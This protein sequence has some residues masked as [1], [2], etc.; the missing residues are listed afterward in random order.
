MAWVSSF[1]ATTVVMATPMLVAAVGT[2][3]VERSGIINIGNEGLMLT[4]AFMGVLGSWLTGSALVGAVFAMLGSAVLGLIFAFF[5]ISL[6]ANQVVS[7]L[8][9]NAMASGLTILLKRMVFGVGG[10]IPQIAVYRK[11]EIPL[12]SKIP[13]IGPTLFNQTLIAYLAI[14]LIPVLTLVLKYTRIGLELRS[15]GENPK[16]CDT[17]GIKVVRVRYLALLFG[18]MM[19]GLGGSFIS[20]GH[21]SFFTEGM[22]AGRGYMTLAAV[23]F[24]NFTPAG[25]LMACLLFGAVDALQYR[26]QAS[27]LGVPYQLMVMLP[28]LATVLAL[29]LY[30]RVSNA[31]A[32]SGVPFIRQ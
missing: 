23:V 24:G 15:V 32:N 6:Y 4:G 31:P 3:F 9:V 1:F 27:S 5:S 21:H 12:L 11:I 8:A 14:L 26:I 20:M 30:R 29:C 7:G 19:A 13:V 2:L 25:V 22:V 16:A 18:S 17:L 28:Y 10:A